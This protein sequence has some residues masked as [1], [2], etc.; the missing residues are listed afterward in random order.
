[1]EDA[2]KYA[3]KACHLGNLQSCINLSVMYQKGEGVARSEDQ[4]KKYTA[5]AREM[6]R[7]LSGDGATLRF[8][9]AKL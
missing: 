5:I 9:E 2:F 3:E 4:S 8:G 1:M 7:Q 6:Q